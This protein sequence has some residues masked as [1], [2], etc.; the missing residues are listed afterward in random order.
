MRIRCTFDVEVTLRGVEGKGKRG[1]PNT[2]K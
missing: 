1:S 2:A